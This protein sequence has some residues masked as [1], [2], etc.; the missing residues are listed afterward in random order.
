MTVRA[1]FVC[2]SV[3]Q[4]KQHDGKVVNTFKF[5]A[6]YGGQGANEENKKFWEATP[7]GSVELSCVREEVKFEIG[8]EYYLDFIPV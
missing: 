4:T 1:K 3:T 5:M 8:K 6:V 7:S 2:Q